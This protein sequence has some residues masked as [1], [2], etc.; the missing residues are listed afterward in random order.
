M[1]GFVSGAIWASFTGSDGSSGRV[2]E[3]TP[4]PVAD[5]E[6][7]DWSLRC[8]KDDKEYLPK[9][10]YALMCCFK[11]AFYQTKWSTSYQPS[12]NNEHWDIAIVCLWDGASLRKAEPITLDKEAL[13][14]S[15][16]FGT[17]NA[18]VHKHCITIARFFVFVRNISIK[19]T[20]KSL[21]GRQQE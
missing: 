15:G 9:S 1:G 16:K 5:F 3:S 10:L 17:H 11:R 2:P 12:I 8:E 20:R 18:K 19:W 21:S 14:I 6:L 4:L 13:L 7:L